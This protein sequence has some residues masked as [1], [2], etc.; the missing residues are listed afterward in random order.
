MQLIVGLGNPGAEYEHT[1]H[2]AGAWF[3]SR[4][5]T[6]ENISFRV[7]KKF[8][9]AIASDEIANKT[10]YFLIPNTFMNESGRSV[11]AVANYYKIAPAAILVAH[12]DL[13]LPPGTV[14]VKRGGGDGGHNGLRDVT[15]AL[16]TSD[17]FRLR[18]GIGHPGH[19]DRVLSYVLN[20]PSK[21]DYERIHTAI[22]DAICMIPSL[23]KGQVEHAM[24]LLHTKK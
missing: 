6:A 18:I 23:V 16:K 20:Q 19:R 12:D 15:A 5:A 8:F 2:N 14:R 21:S 24:K 1:R 22:D 11:T 7:E 17:Y 9:G 3:V 10:I 13:D 4:L